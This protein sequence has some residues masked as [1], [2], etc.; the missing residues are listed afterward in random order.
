[1]KG[2]KL[3]L[4]G[5]LTLI[6]FSI[7]AVPKDPVPGNKEIVYTLH[8]VQHEASFV[9]TVPAVG[10][11]TNVTTIGKQVDTGG[12]TTIPTATEQAVSVEVNTG[13]G[14]TLFKASPISYCDKRN[15]TV[16]RPCPWSIPWYFLS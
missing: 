5:L 8:A 15:V 14:S 12:L 1:M 6:G 7:A 10:H 9:A 3:Y 16:I 13:Q 4:L 11:L 2:F